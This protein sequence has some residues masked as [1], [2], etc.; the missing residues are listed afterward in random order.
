MLYHL[1][2]GF[3]NPFLVL[4][5][6]MA[7]TLVWQWRKSA[8]GT[9][10]PLLVLTVLYSFLFV[11]C[12]PVTAFVLN[13]SLEWSFPPLGS[14]PKDAQAIV[15][16]GGGVHRPVAP[17]QPSELG[18]S[19][20]VRC[21]RAAQV[22]HDGDPCPLF[23]VGGNP[24]W[25]VGDPVAQVMAD[26]LRGFR[27]PDSDLIVESKSRDT[28]ENAAASAKLLSQRGI[29]KIVLVTS[30]AHLWRA[31]HLF[32]RHGLEVIAAGCDYCDPLDVNVF[33]ILPSVHSADLNH[34]VVHEWFGVVKLW[35][36]GRW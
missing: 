8:R 20:L 3:T 12:L 32:R 1:V 35:A 24:D 4:M 22:Y 18:E 10:R 15:V 36:Q 34:Q 13:G 25:I 23:V 26:L 5:L 17:G 7:A 6:T 27:V 31:S 29:T 21:V 30:A 2:I 16:L 14:R 9:R 11:Y 33:M 19:S 28:F